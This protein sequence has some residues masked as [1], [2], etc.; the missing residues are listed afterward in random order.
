MK[1]DYIIMSS[2]RGEE[3]LPGKIDDIQFLL[4]V[5]ISS[6]H[7]K[8]VIQA[9]GEYLVYGYSRKE[10]CSRHSVSLSYFSSALK[11]LRKINQCIYWL[12][13]FYKK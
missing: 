13:P 3:L 2:E 1:D 5:E 7:S 9:L 10:A 8:K 11:K 4:L 6:I 12:V